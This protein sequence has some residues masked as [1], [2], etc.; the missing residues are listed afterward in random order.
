MTQ[1]LQRII[2]LLDE[3]KAKFLQLLEMQNS[4]TPSPPP[5]P[6]PVPVPTPAP[7]PSPSPAPAPSPV[8][9]FSVTDSQNNVWGIT[10]ERK[11]VKNGLPATT[12]DYTA[13]V[14]EL[15]LHGDTPYQVNDVGATYRFTGDPDWEPVADPRVSPV[16]TPAPVPSPT[17]VPGPTGT[18]PG[19][20]SA[21]D[22]Q[23]DLLSLG[24]TKYVFAAGETVPVRATFNG[25]NASS[26]KC[27]LL[28]S[29]EEPNESGFGYL[30]NQYIDFAGK[31]S[32]EYDLRF[33]PGHYGGKFRVWLMHV[34]SGTWKAV[35]IEHGGGGTATPVP[36]PT[37]AP[38]PA[39][40]PVTGAPS[41]SYTFSGKTIPSYFV[42]IH[43]NRYPQNA[44]W[45]G[46]A[47]VSAAPTFT[48]A[49]VNNWDY[50]ERSAGVHMISQPAIMDTYMNRFADKFI[51]DTPA[52]MPVEVSKD[53]LHL[54]P[55][56]WPGC[57]G[58]LDLNLREQYKAACVARL[59]RYAGKIKVINPM[60][61]PDFGSVDPNKDFFRGSMANAAEIFLVWREA[62]NETD[63]SVKLIGN[64]GVFW[65]GY[66]GQTGTVGFDTDFDRLYQ[67]L[68]VV[69]SNGQRV[70][71][72]LDGCAVHHYGTSASDAFQI[73]RVI[74]KARN[75]C[76]SHGRDL[77]IWLT[78]VGF[79][80]GRVP[81]SATGIRIVKR[82]L[83]AAAAAGAQTLCLYSYDGIFGNLMNM[84]T[85]PDMQ[86][87]FTQ[88]S[89][90]LNGKTITSGWI[91][92]NGTV[93]LNFNNG[94]SKIV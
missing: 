1:I 85:N 79:V 93:Q 54:G 6:T 80:D 2:E 3:L 50:S 35:W 58:E 94:V 12:P 10:T 66:H 71:D 72:M 49:T 64:S 87:A 30:A 32:G 18:E 63:R 41:G 23:I 5:G 39:P 67:F 65:D 36:T 31:A 57:T 26:W 44:S 8:I 14:R 47:P 28:K 60:N 90:M 27:W 11:I 21:G 33:P 51:I 61:E 45:A 55:Y 73:V 48:F 34:P 81:D 29:T 38:T 68:G 88:M 77:P 78:E 86:Q 75:S 92:P 69:A 83:A 70:I 40:S 13:N 43:F 76:K 37:P 24:L 46:A 22:G 91:A 84:D 74:E 16:P 15:F 25:S 42:G 4:P 17:P 7:T 82:W 59:R 56:N 62:I 53:D 52:F 89:N 9:V 20:L 19:S